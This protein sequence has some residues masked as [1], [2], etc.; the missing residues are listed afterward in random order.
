MNPGITSQNCPHLQFFASSLHSAQ[1]IAFF[2]RD[3]TLNYDEGY[4]YKKED[5]Q[6]LPQG[7]EVLRIA[8]KNGWTPVVVSNQ[9]GI[10]RG[11]YTLESAKAF[12][13]ELRQAFL[14]IDLRIDYFIF[15]THDN[16]S[17]CDFRKPASGML[18][19]VFNS[20][21]ADLFVMFGNSISDSEAAAKAKIVYS[22]ISK[23]ESCISILDSK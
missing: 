11:F 2:D 20:S 17:N 14:Q 4:T 16:F 15:C 10:S 21:Q 23:I 12:N 5:L 8:I 13:S 6:L 9:S 22:D 7:T 3:G 1:K 19:L 18:D